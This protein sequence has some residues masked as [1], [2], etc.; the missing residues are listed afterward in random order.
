MN[1]TAI[2]LSVILFASLA[3]AQQSS[4]GTQR[5]MTPEMR[6]QFEKMRPV[7]DLA[8]MV[9]LLPDLEKS[10]VT[11]LT[12]AQAGQ[13]LPILKSLQSGQNVDPNNAKKYLAQI[14]DKIL[15]SKQLTAVDDLALKAEKE[16][17]ARRAQ[18]QRNGQANTRIP[19]MPPGMMTGQ[20]RPGQN[21]QSGQNRTPSQFN[22][23]KQG[24]TAD[25]LKAYMAI[26]QKKL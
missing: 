17:A 12:R 1:K 2:P 8:A 13:L 5:Q 18:T 24:R 11:A 19:G 9:R 16:R 10:K 21:A 7:M 26:L 25:E 20:N 23:F 3:S 6:A 22:P 15:T 14:E 4:P